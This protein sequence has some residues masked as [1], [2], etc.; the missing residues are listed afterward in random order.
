MIPGEIRPPDA[1]RT[2][3]DT[4]PAMTMA[5]PLD[6]GQDAERGA[7]DRTDRPPRRIVAVTPVHN[8]RRLTLD[9]LRTMFASELDGIDLHVIVVDDGSTDGTSEAIHSMFSQVEV[10]R[11]DGT[12]HYTAGA[13]VGLRAAL[14]QAPDYVLLF[15]DDSRFPAS[16]L[17]TLV[18]CAEAYPSSV[19]SPLLQN[20]D[21]P[22]AIF[23]VAPTWD[24]LYGGWR[25]WTRQRLDTVPELPFPVEAI[26]GNC[27][28]IP[29]AA[30][31]GVGIMR[32]DL[33]KYGD[34]ELTVRMRRSGYRLLVEPRARLLCEPNAVSPRLR[35]M[36]LTQLWD[37]LI[38]RMKAQNN[39]R[40]LFRL[41][42]HSAPS[43]ARGA[44]AFAVFLLRAVARRLGIDRNWPGNLAE[45]PLVERVRPLDAEPG[46]IASAVGPIL[47]AWPYKEW[48]GIQTYFLAL[49]KRARTCGFEVRILMPAETPAEFSAILAQHGFTVEL[50]DGRYDLD[51]AP[52]LRRRLERRLR[53]WRTD[54]EMVARITRQSQ[55]PSLVHIDVA[56]WSRARLLRKLLAR[57]PVLMTIHT[58]LAEVGPARGA[59]WS[60]RLRAFLKHPRARLLVANTAARLSLLRYLPADR[61]DYIE[62][63]PSCFVQD[64]IALAASATPSRPELE[65]RLRLPPAEFRILVGAQFIERKGCHVL[66]EAIRQLVAAGTVI[67]CVW[68]TPNPPDPELVD[69][70]DSRELAPSFIL[71]T[72]AEIGGTPQAYLGAVAR[73]CDLFVLP[74]L[75][76]GLPLALVEA[77]ALGKA[78]L[79]TRVNAVPELIRHGVS[80]WLV[81]PADAQSLAQAI[82]FLMSDGPLRRR[83]GA[84]AHAEVSSRYESSVATRATLAA[85]LALTSHRPRGLAS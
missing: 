34:T 49:A 62:C 78:C 46:T 9:C 73:L 44:T 27:M 60:W 61:L 31:Q 29:L 77:M 6:I 41:N 72:Q 26:V 58:P 48:G 63:C 53:D 14:A 47:Y 64:D 80:G 70:L 45:Q 51:P 10:I 18:E 56:P 12:L 3:K 20:W 5:Y 1:M 71:L 68:I 55:P 59:L 40:E 17:K 85:Y 33:P 28:L 23:Q 66:I 76:E 24:T 32:E 79:A 7:I 83:L 50:L 13:N 42:W 65:R 35:D 38:T 22:Q 19:V 36:S 11:A 84:V 54:R 16:C 81:P 75:L 25:H 39:L 69:R 52:S 2:D 8:R 15:N 57:F 4:R 30:L 82:R 21:R 37:T 67:Q 74:S 43:H